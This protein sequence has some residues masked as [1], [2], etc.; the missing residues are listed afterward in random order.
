[1]PTLISS[2]F[3]RVGAASGTLRSLSSMIFSSSVAAISLAEPTSNSSRAIDLSWDGVNTSP[4]GAKKR[5]SHYLEDRISRT[6]MLLHNLPWTK[7]YL[8]YAK[9]LVGMRHLVWL[10]SPVGQ[11]ACHLSLLARHASCTRARQIPCR[12]LKPHQV[13]HGYKCL[14][15]A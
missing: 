7:D 14:G 10:R 11:T 5:H 9:T 3:S 13:P 4:K 8:S 2:Q 15:E 12:T 6:K 1:M